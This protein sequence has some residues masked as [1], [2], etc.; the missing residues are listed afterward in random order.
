MLYLFEDSKFE[1][2][3]TFLGIVDSFCWLEYGFDLQSFNCCLEIP[4][5]FFKKWLLD[6]KDTLLAV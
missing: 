6:G 2:D 5:F 4:L 3:C 1:I